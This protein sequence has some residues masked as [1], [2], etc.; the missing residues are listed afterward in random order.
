MKTLWRWGKRLLLALVLTVLA[1]LAPVAWTEVN[2]RGPVLTDD[3]PSLIAPEFVRPE[4]RTLMTY[5]EWHIVHAYADYAAVIARDAPHDFAFVTPIRQFWGSLCQLTKAADGM[6]G[7]DGATRQMVYTIGV[8]F[9]AELLAKA[10]YEET[11]GRLFVWLRGPTRAPLDDLSATQAANYAEFLQQVPWYKW[12]FRADRAA[13][14]AA[15]SGRLR[16]VERSLALGIEYG[17]K[18]QYAG[19][20]AA[21]VAATGQDAL[22]MRVIVTGLSA[23]ELAET[24]DV[25]VITERPEGIEVET[26]RYAAFTTLA[27]DWAVKGAQFVEI[28]GNDDILFTAITTEPTLPGALASFPRQGREDFRHLMLVKVADLAAALASP[29]LQIEH[30]HDY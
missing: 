2:C 13:L 7:A 18:A 8:S 19:V 29:V 1:L 12:D 16:D 14:W 5:P 26:P 17:V 25:V 10:A 4:S 30:L 20:I 27:R 11:F 21:A 15:S 22:R 9:T 3:S 24:P 28:A 6:G 23:A